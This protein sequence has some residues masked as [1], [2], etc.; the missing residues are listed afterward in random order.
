MSRIRAPQR[1]KLDDS[2]PASDVE[3]QDIIEEHALS[4]EVEPCL[5]IPQVNIKTVKVA[6]SQ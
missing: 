3:A 1:C 5:P 2:R 4:F 6:L